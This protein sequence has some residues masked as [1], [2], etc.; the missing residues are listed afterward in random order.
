MPF[1]VQW[2]PYNGD[3]LQNEKSVLIIGMSSCSIVYFTAFTLHRMSKLGPNTDRQKV[4]GA[5]LVWLISLRHRVLMLTSM[6]VALGADLALSLA[7]QTDQS[8]SWLFAGK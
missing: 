2:D 5:P 1:S 7:G 4:R 8:V 3:T 6:L